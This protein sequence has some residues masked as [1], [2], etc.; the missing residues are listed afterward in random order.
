MALEVNTI[1][2]PINEDMDF[3]TKLHS[4]ISNNTVIVM[5][6]SLKDSPI[7]NL[8]PN[9][10]RKVIIT[11]TAEINKIMDIKIEKILPQNL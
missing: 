1:L 11:L 2:I 5:A 7:N 9:D 10:G 8:D 3:M 6:K 4:E